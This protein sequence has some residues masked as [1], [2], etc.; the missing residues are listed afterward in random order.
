M[1]R[2]ASNPVDKAA[3]AHLRR[4][5]FTVWSVNW[6]RAHEGEFC[7][8]EAQGPDFPETIEKL[9]D[10]NPELILVRRDARLWY[11]AWNTDEQKRM[12]E[13]AYASLAD[14]FNDGTPGM[15]G[16]MPKLDDFDETAQIRGERYAKAHS[17]PWPPETG[18]YDRFWE[19]RN[20]RTRN[21][22]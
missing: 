7:G 16:E 8:I 10:K 20:S 3:R 12:D 5:G 1:V 9:L 2:S 21:P 19:R 11:F 22:S 18:D 15:A 13:D 17:L 14:E 6:L 4:M